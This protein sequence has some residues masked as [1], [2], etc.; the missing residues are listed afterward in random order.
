MLLRSSST[1]VP[2]SWLQYSKDSTFFDQ[3]PEMVQQIQRTRS[4][5]L[6]AS[7]RSPLLLSP[8]SDSGRRLTR[9]VSEDDLRDFMVARPKRKSFSIP[10]DG[11]EER[12]E[13]NE[14]KMEMGFSASGL[15]RTASLGLA[16]LERCEAGL[17]EDRRLLSDLEG[18]GVGGGGGKVC[19]GNGGGRGESDDGDDEGNG[20]WESNQGCASTD[21]YYQKIIDANPGNPMLLGNYARFLKEVQEDF[22]KAE[23]YCGRA[24]LECPNDG[25]VLS[26]FADLVW[27]IHKDAPRAQSYFDQ[28]VQAAPD[29]SYVLASYAKFLW[30]SEEEDEEEEEEE[31][32]EVNLKE[33]GNNRASPTNLFPGI[34]PSPPPLAAAA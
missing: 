32:E 28:A 31:E 19:G 3:Q 6:S 13:R 34:P 7:S 18:G 21:L 15:G 8:I 16:E 14:I 9:A 20:F 27:Q 23:E 22:G 33:G 29:D 2:N 11:F 1:P 4:V 24:I 26:M 25:T 30:D 5:T 17:R 10:M 12:E